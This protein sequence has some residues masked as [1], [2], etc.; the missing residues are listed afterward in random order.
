[1]VE[2]IDCS[3]QGT[4]V[5]ITAAWLGGPWI[6]GEISALF[7]GVQSENI[8]LLGYDSVHHST[9]FLVRAP[10]QQEAG[11]VQGLV[12]DHYRLASPAEGKGIGTFAEQPGTEVGVGMV[13]TVTVQ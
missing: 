9:T 3:I 11:T 6:R 2:P 4:V 1:M 8:T 13:T 7:G 10:N 5:T 12:E